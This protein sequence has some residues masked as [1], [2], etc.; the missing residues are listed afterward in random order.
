DAVD[1]ILDELGGAAGVGELVTELM[2]R[3]GEGLTAATTSE[4]ARRRAEGILRIVVDAR[5]HRRRAAD[6]SRP[7]P[8]ERRRGDVVLALGRDADLLSLA[9][10]LGD[11]AK[12][13][14]AELVGVLP[15]RRSRALVPPL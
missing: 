7:P 15:A 9:V 2:R 8:E 14:V 1:A 13:A 4:S 12:Q 10:R 6:G 11:A 5:R 3:A